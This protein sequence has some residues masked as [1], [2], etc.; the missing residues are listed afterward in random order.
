[1]SQFFTGLGTLICLPWMVV[2]WV[3]QWMKLGFKEGQDT[4]QEQYAADCEEKRTRW[5]SNTK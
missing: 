3:Y 1:M 4:A 2:G 5:S